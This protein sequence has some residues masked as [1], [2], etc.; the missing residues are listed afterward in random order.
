MSAQCSRSFCRTVEWPTLFRGFAARA[1]CLRLTLPT[2]P[3]SSTTEAF[4][5]S[6]IMARSKQSNPRRTHCP[7]QHIRPTSHRYRPSTAA[8]RLIRRVECHSAKLVIRKMPFQRLVRELAL[9]FRPSV[10]FQSGAV[11]ALHHAAEAYLTSLFCE[12]NVCATAARRT[13]VHVRDLQLAR[14]IRG[15][16]SLRL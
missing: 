7:A 15:E 1:R 8:L 6:A 10:C 4:S 14:R 3:P 13:L 12:A 5:L 2:L 11:L 16:P 9:Q